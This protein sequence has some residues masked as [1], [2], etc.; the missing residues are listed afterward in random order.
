MIDRVVADIPNAEQGLTLIFSSSPF[1][2][3]Q[4]RLDWHCEE[5]GGN[6]Y[7]SEELK[8]VDEGLSHQANPRIIEDPKP[9]MLVTASCNRSRLRL[10][11]E[12]GVALSP[13]T[14]ASRFSV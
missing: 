3:H 2:A 10:I 12:E 8:M 1:P 7:H 9:E 14:T 4:Y 13:T 6:W 5:A 11:P